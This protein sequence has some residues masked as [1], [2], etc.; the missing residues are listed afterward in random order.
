[1]NAPFHHV[2]GKPRNEEV[3]NSY[4]ILL[5]IHESSN[6]F[7]SLFER[8]R[9]DRGAKGTSTDEEQDLLRAMFLFASAGLDSMVKQLVL[10]ALHAVIRCDEGAHSLFVGHL[11]KRLQRGEATDYRV[12]AKALSSNNPKVSMID[13]L[14]Y[15]LRSNSLQS[16]DQL[17]KVASHFNI[18][19]NALTSDFSLLNTTS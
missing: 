16:K 19:S 2:P 8:I 12:L 6:S 7:C 15:S 10:D 11:E 17:L 18:S 13:D 5:S 14:V 1:M 4:F 3:M 9:H